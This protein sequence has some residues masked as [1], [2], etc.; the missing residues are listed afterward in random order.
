VEAIFYDAPRMVAKL[1]CES[2]YIHYQKDG[3]VLRGRI[4]SGDT[5]V[6]QISRPHHEA[7]AERLGLDL[8]NFWEN[9]SYARRLY[10]K[11]GDS[12]WLAPVDCSQVA[13]ANVQN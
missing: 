6:A 4:T 2:N 12:P 5:G 3:T 10:N 7:N 1:K 9:L 13:L 11:Q 8:D